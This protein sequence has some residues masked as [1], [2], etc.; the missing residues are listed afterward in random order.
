MQ[1]IT[2]TGYCSSVHKKPYSRVNKK[3]FRPKKPIVVE[4]HDA[5]HGE[6]PSGLFESNKRKLDD[7]ISDSESSS[8]D[9]DYDLSAQDLTIH[10]HGDQFLESY[11]SPMS[12]AITPSSSSPAVSTSE[13]LL[14]QNLKRKRKNQVQIVEETLE[15]QN[16][17]L[18]L[19]TRAQ[20]SDEWKI[21]QYFMKG[22][23]RIY[24]I[25]EFENMNSV[26][27]GMKVKNSNTF[28]IGVIIKIGDISFPHTVSAGQE[29][30]L[31]AA[32]DNLQM[33]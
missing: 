7:Y 16:I 20:P 23:D 15:E 32:G 8:E 10:R 25:S 6:S 11:F 2:T 27:L 12:S 22:K 18:E 13:V 19:V 5:G 21:P 26:F 9:D 29:Y 17:F 14:L 1:T 30:I 3:M 24:C 33:K 31:S 28:D 4:D